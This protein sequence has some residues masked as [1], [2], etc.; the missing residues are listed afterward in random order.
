MN[1]YQNY[2]GI[3]VS[4]ETLDVA[5]VSQKKKIFL[6]KTSNDPKALKALAKQLKKNRI[7]FEKSLFC[8]EHTGI[9]TEHILAWATENKLAIW[10][11]SGMQIKKS[12]GIKREKTDEV[13]AYHIAMYAFRFEDKCKLWEAPSE[14]IKK[15]KYLMS[16]RERLVKS[17][18]QFS[19]PLKESKQ[20]L[21][22][23][24]MKELEKH[25]K[26]AL[27]GLEKSLKDTES[28]IQQIIEAHADIKG[29]YDLITS[30]KGIGA[31]T[32]VTLIIFSNA[33]KNLH[34]ARIIAC[35][36]GIAPFQYASGTS[37]K[38][39]TKV[40][41]FANKKLKT[42]FHLAARTAIHH[43]PKMKA[44]KER[45]LKEGKHIMSIMNAVR[46]KLL[47]IVCACVRTGQ[48]YDE[49]YRLKFA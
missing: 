27:K 11:E 1:N 26:T 34:E 4:K 12:L 16:L 2:I 48:K 33:F 13:D 17:I 6:S 7:L 37:I 24:Q 47:H 46:N 15:L 49:N 31:V 23:Q 40:S 35:Y 22:K 38:G 9:Y 21:P 41:H 42:L 29:K 32:A 39:R 10:V 20:F 30:V 5:V 18:S 19:V 43:S 25:S 14:A 45:K 36:A 28:T 8:V 3:D 44:Y